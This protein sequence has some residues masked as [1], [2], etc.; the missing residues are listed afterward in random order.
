[1]RGI[2]E[3]ASYQRDLPWQASLL[4]RIR[5]RTDKRRKTTVLAVKKPSSLWLE[6]S[7]DLPRAV[8]V[9]QAFFRGPS[10]A[11]RRAFRSGPIWCIRPARIRPLFVLKVAWTFRGK[12]QLRPGSNGLLAYAR[13]PGTLRIFDARFQQDSFLALPAASLTAVL[14]RVNACSQVTS[15]LLHVRPSFVRDS[16]NP[17]PLTHDAV[18]NGTWNADLFF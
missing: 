18:W 17:K 4:H 10:V 7:L 9:R 14:V 13:N 11:L 6:A 16:G 3:P 2:P 12:T 1:M 5:N 8:I 15:S